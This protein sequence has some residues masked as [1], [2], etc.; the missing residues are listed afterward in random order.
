[1][2][3]RVSVDHFTSADVFSGNCLFIDFLGGGTQTHIKRLF[4]PGII[5]GFSTNGWCLYPPGLSRHA[6][7]VIRFVSLIQRGTTGSGNH[8]VQMW[9]TRMDRLPPLFAIIFG[10][11]GGE[12]V[13]IFQHTLADFQLLLRAEVL[14]KWVSA[15]SIF[16]HKNSLTQ[17]APKSSE[18]KY[19]RLGRHRLFFRMLTRS[20]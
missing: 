18:I 17:E 2:V 9:Q 6:L 11:M 10:S 14:R 7:T 3:C 20:G 8:V 15:N 13:P 16:Y 1:M 4:T 19:S 5:W 12:S